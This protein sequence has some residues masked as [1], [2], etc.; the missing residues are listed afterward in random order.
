MNHNITLLIGQAVAASRHAYAPYSEYAVGAALVGTDGQ[1]FT[2][3]NVENASYPA[4]ICAERGALMKAVSEGV[5]KFD[6]IVVATRN[7]GS[8]CGVCRQMLSEFGID[9]RVIT[10]TFEGDIVLDTTLAALLPH[11]FAP[12]HL[13]ESPSED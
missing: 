4:S 5:Q 1:T 6:V 7:G 9:L 8:P 2:G 3:C 11:S 10:V 12:Q 13:Q